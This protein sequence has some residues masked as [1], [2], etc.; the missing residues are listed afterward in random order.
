M[1]SKRL[2]FP[3]ITCIL[4]QFGY[5]IHQNNYTKRKIQISLGKNCKNLKDKVTKTNYCKT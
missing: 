3:K 2:I 1:N 4:Y 5:I